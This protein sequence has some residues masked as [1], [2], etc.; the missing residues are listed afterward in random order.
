MTH[1]DTNPLSVIEQLVGALEKRIN[2]S[3]DGHPIYPQDLE[4]H[5]TVTAGRQALE[6]A[7]GEVTKE[8]AELL[9]RVIEQFE[10]DGETD[11]DYKTLMRFAAMGLLECTHFEATSKGAEIAAQTDAPLFATHPQASEPLSH[12]KPE[13]PGITGGAAI[14]HEN[15]QASEPAPAKVT[16][17]GRYAFE[18]EP[19]VAGA[20]DC[21][22]ASPCTTCPDKRQCAK[23]GCV[24]QKE[25]VGEVKSKPANEMGNLNWPRVVWTAGLFAM[26]PVGTKLYTT[27]QPSQVAQIAELEETVRQL[28]RALRDATEAPTFMGEPMQL[29]LATE[30]G[31][32]RYVNVHTTPP[33][34]SPAQPVNPHTACGCSDQSDCSGEC[35]VAQP[36]VAD[37]AVALVRQQLLNTPELRDFGVGVTLEALHQRERWG[38]NHDADKTPADWFW[39]VGYLAG[40]ALHAQTGGNTEKALHHTIS[41][42]AALANWHAAIMEVQS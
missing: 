27:P 32:T 26:P 14:T 17:L 13:S 18:P 30:D 40:K 33:Q 25:A 10:D 5:N 8:D 15:G 9:A 1:P 29:A 20:A 3:E 4:D 38:S 22:G 37:D 36:V 24:R 7:Q 21:A 34:P 41:T 39:L 16:D 12:A 6:K 23:T 35:C 31:G 28:N 42:A 11:V 19:G 2:Y